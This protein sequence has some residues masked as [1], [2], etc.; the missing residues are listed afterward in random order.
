MFAQRVQHGGSCI[1]AERF[2]FAVDAQRHIDRQGGIL[3]RFRR[4]GS[5]AS[6]S[7]IYRPLSVVS[8][9]DLIGKRRSIICSSST[10]GLANSGRR[11]DSSKV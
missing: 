5:D 6:R 8:S 1:Q 11:Q 10:G 3:R 2:A 4:I 7:N 9:N